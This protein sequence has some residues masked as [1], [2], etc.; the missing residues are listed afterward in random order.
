MCKIRNQEPQ[1]IAL[2]HRDP[3][4]LED[5]NQ[6][7]LCYGFRHLFE[8]SQPESWRLKGLKMVLDRRAKMFAPPK[9][10]V[11]QQGYPQLWLGQELMLSTLC[12]E[13]GLHDGFEDR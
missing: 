7:G 12:T 13:K 1:R 5:E 8:E 11:I 3:P 2:H 6:S 9:H 10:Q 4:K